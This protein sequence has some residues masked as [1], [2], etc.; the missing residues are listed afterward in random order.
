MGD[1]V[2]GFCGTNKCKREVMAMSY[3]LQ[4]VDELTLDANFAGKYSGTLHFDLPDGW[5]RSNTVVVGAM[6]I[7]DWQEGQRYHTWQSIGAQNQIEEITISVIN[8]DSGSQ[9]SVQF[10]DSAQLSPKVRI[11]LMNIDELPVTNKGTIT[12]G[13]T[14]P[15]LGG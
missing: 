2:Y 11:L 4:Y 13:G 15:P 3:L 12:G 10:T 8:N 5:D 1:K 9:L 14:N 7:P 6:L